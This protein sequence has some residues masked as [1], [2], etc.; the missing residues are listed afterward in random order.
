[1]NEVLLKKCAVVRIA[2]FAV[3]ATVFTKD[4]INVNPGCA[5]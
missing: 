2:S 3:P 5:M 4:I 1:M